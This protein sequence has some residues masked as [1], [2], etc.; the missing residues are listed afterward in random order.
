MPLFD[1]ANR[2]LR[3]IA[4]VDELHRV[5]GIARREHLAAACDARGP[6]REAVAVVARSDDQAGRTIVARPGNAFSASFSASAFSPPYVSLRSSPPSGLRARS[7]RRS[8]PCS[9]SSFLV[10]GDRRD[11]HVLPAESFSSVAASRTPRRQRGR[12]VDHRVPLAALSASSFPLRSPSSRSTPAGTE[13]GFVLPRVEHRDLV[14][15]AHRVPHLVRSDE[16]GA[17]EDEDAEGLGRAGL[18]TSAS[19][20]VAVAAA[21]AVTNVGE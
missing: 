21:A 10:D 16:A 19:A 20:T 7:W 8:R 13:P 17:A 9:S 18:S 4:R 2:E 14:S 6:V 5:G 11:E 1:E 12:V 15:A 3:E